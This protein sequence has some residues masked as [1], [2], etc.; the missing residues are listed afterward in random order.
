M[1]ATL[2]PRDAGT[3]AGLIATQILGFALGRY[4]LKLPPIVAMDRDDVIAWLGPTLQ[5]YLDG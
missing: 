5:R 2:A 1:V 4:V 3:R